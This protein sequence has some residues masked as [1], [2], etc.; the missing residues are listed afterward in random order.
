MGINEGVSFSQAEVAALSLLQV[1]ATLRRRALQVRQLGGQLVRINSHL[2]PELSWMALEER[3]WDFG[4]SDQLMA[5]LGATGLDVVVV[6]GPWPGAQTARYTDRYLPEDLDGYTAYVERVVERYDGDGIAD[7]PGLRR[8][9]LAWEI[10]NEPDLHNQAPPRDGGHR[11]APGS[12]QTAAEYAQLLLLSAQAVHRAAPD[13]FVLSAGIYRPMTP[14]GRDY[15]QAVL[16]TPGVID[17]IDGISLHCY[18]SEDRLSVISEM[19]QTARALA[20]DHPLW[21]TE[22]SV[23]S[24]GRTAWADEDWQAA[25]VVAVHGALLAEGADRILWHSL[26]EPPQRSDTRRGFGSN[27][28]L[29]LED[30]GALRDKPAAEVY[31][32]LAAILADVPADPIAEIAAEGG[33]LLETEAGWL[34][35]WGQPSPPAAATRGIDL[36]TGDTFPVRGPVAAP[37]WLPR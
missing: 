37:A 30:D 20:P 15:L 1:K 18:F 14:S 21:I 17:A 12:F 36:L 34:A 26:I 35:F 33:R 3:A 16:Q 29:R 7:M 9:V 10:D 31:R 6:L 19:M 4:P 8:P 25:M 13:A 2:Y 28:L 24:D 23:P 5:V 22:T 27:S 32:R 11:V